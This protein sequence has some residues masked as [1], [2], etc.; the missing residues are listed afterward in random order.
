MDRV[1]RHPGACQPPR[2]LSTKCRKSGRQRETCRWAVA[3][4][5]DDLRRAIRRLARG[6]WRT[7]YLG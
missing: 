1:A 5:M 4:G 2:R 6:T 3:W 7:L